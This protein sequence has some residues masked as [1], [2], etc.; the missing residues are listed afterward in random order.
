MVLS[1]GVCVVNKVFLDIKN[2]NNV[3]ILVICDFF[4][5][6]YLGEFVVLIGLFGVGKS[7]LLNIMVGF[8]KDFSGVIIYGDN[9]LNI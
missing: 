4:L 9:M 6:I 2:L 7:M 3:K 1:Y 8:D 5:I